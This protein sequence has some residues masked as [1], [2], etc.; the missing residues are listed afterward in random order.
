MARSAKL[1]DIVVLGLLKEQP[2]YGYEIKMI[3]DHVMSHIIDVSSG[4]L[5]YGI[6]KLQQG[7]YIEEATVEK[8]GRRPERSVY[9]I[10]E[11]GTKLFDRELPKVIFPR[12]RPTL[13]L[14]LGLYFFD[15]ID[16]QEGQRRLRM[17]LERIRLTIDFV[18]DLKR[19]YKDSAPEPHLLILDHNL[20]YYDAE[21]KFLSE[22][23]KRMFKGEKCELTSRD[24]QEV[25]A[26][27]EE[28]K[29]QFDYEAAT[30]TPGTTGRATRP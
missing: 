10:T 4:S 7:G 17:W 2:R 23:I 27:V 15:A 8:V 28:L 18:K 25:E 6:K 29:Q 9:N 1:R 30:T 3:I 19:R 12:A 21:Q 16:R 22:T 24:L 26:E 20:C 5:Y 13:P 11:A 14:N